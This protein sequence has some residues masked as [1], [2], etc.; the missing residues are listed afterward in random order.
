VVSI[1]PAQARNFWLLK[2]VTA[3]FLTSTLT[4]TLIYRTLWKK[5]SKTFLKIII[6]WKSNP[7]PMQ[8]NLNGCGSI[9]HRHYRPPPKKYIGY[10]LTRGKARSTYA[11]VVLTNYRMENSN[12]C[13]G[14]L[15][16][17]PFLK[18]IKYVTESRNFI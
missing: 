8:C 11:P 14:N 4:L 13:P 18:S 16:H 5:T 10:S 12:G 15:M 7:R 17:K 2:D 6:A 3:I 9:M 1:Q